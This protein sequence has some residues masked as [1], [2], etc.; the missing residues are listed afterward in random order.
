[1]I[2]NTG[3]V[4]TTYD[5]SVTGLPAGVTSSFSAASVTVQPGQTLGAGTGAPTLTLT[6]PLDT[7][8]PANFTVSAVAE[9]APEI[10]LSSPGLLTLRPES[11]LVGSIV[12]TPPYTSAGGM[13]DVSAKIQAAVN[14]PTTVS[15]SFTVTDPGGNILFTSAAMP[16]ALT[17]T[18]SV[19]TVD[20]GNVDTTGFA[21]GTD[22]ITVN[23]SSGAPATTP[24]FIGQPVTGS[25]TTTPSVIPTGSNTVS[26]TVTVS[27]QASYP[28]P[29]ILQGGV[30]TPAPGRRWRSTPR[31]DRPTP[32]KAGPA[33]STTST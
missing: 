5:L 12:L 10:T 4:A 19:A 11:I 31:A 30:T 28:I 29:L 8:V 25:V 13:V 18:T 15:A 14:E 9:G 2:K 6:E 32:T 27:T 23:L 3:S 33:A 16:V 7:L 17:D 20:L 21:D 24:L 22:T 26:T 1:M